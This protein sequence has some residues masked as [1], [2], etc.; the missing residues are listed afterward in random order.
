MEDNIQLIV[1]GQAYE[2]WQEV[3][4]QQSIM[5][6]AGSFTI[7]AIDRYPGEPGS[8]GMSMGSECQIK[9]NGKNI[10][11]GY[12]DT[13][14]VNYSESEHVLEVNGRDKTGDLVDCSY[15]VAGKNEWVNTTALSI[16]TSLVAPFGIT[17]EV[18]ASVSSAVSAK[19]PKFS[20]NVGDTIFTLIDKLG[21]ALG[22]I[23]IS[24]G[25][26][27]LTLT[28]AGDTYATDSLKSGVNIKAGALIQSNVDRYQTY[29]VLGQNNGTD[30]ITPTASTQPIGSYTDSV[31]NRERTL[32][33]EADTPIDI[34]KAREQAQWEAL[35]RAGKSRSVKY[36]VLGWSQTN[37]NPWPLNK[38]IQVYDKALSINEAFLITA[39]TFTL[40]I[41]E[42]ARTQLLLMNP[43]AFTPLSSVLGIKTNF[44]E[45]SSSDLSFLS[46]LE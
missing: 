23:P 38:L 15:Y 3:A 36:T 8:W 30:F 22:F 37:G 5:Q 12:I 6:I 28:S 39:I 41:E 1:N 19:I 16:I 34:K 33:I 24:T 35:V 10:I 11:D 4:V 25:N 42:G 31:I 46:K 20:S 7:R 17:L 2:G 44:D 26:G 29:Y 45:G 9:I 14:P 27:K 21:K 40:S 43:N 13:L 18:N 32:V